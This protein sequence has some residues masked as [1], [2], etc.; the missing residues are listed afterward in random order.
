MD[1]QQ[2]PAIGSPLLIPFDGSV[3]A[4][5]VFPF[6][7]FLLNADRQIILM[8]VVPTAQAVADPIGTEMLSSR[9]VQRMSDIAAEQRSEGRR[10][11]MTLSCAPFIVGRP[12]L[13]R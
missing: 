11:A 2:H 5:A 12:A 6:V 8:Q 13:V 4:E 7:P 10:L 9:D 3:N 1:A